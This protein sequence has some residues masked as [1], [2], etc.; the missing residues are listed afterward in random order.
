MKKNQMDCCQE[1]QQ[2]HGGKN[3]GCHLDVKIDVTK[4]VK[5]ICFTVLCIAA[6]RYL[7]AVIKEFVCFEEE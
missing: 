6:V 2:C 5:C 1:K 4:I 3:K 7:P